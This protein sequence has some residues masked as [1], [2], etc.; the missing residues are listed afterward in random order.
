MLHQFG[1][2]LVL[3]FARDSLNSIISVPEPNQS[4]RKRQVKSQE[5]LE[6][7]DLEEPAHVNSKQEDGKRE[8]N[9][10][11]HLAANFKQVVTLFNFYNPPPASHQSR[12]EEDDC[13]EESDNH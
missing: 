10:G 1:K 5:N 12:R 7:F 9:K 3:F 13:K 2:Q 8:R 11:K 4:Q 6:E